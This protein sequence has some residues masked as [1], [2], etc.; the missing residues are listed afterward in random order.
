[1]LC[2]TGANAI[3]AP[4]GRRDFFS[5]AKQP[6]RSHL[7]RTLSRNF[8]VGHSGHSLWD[9]WDTLRGTLGT[10]WKNTW[11]TRYTSL[12]HYCDLLTIL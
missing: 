8:D 4:D 10:L 6:Q 3:S 9:T 2:L 11:D 7:Q 1:M 12:G 5:T